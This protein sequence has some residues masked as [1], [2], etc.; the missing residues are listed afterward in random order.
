[1]RNALERSFRGFWRTELPS[2][3]QR[4]PISFIQPCLSLPKTHFASSLSP[5]FV[6]CLPSSFVSL[7]LRK[8]FLSTSN[9]RTKIG[10]KAMRTID[11]IYRVNSIKRPSKRAESRK[12][13]SSSQRTEPSGHL[14]SEAAKGKKTNRRESFLC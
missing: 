4:F 1:M 5:S 9:I 14:R 8:F 6:S 10:V 2:R 7:S 12:I 3:T 11:V 13:I